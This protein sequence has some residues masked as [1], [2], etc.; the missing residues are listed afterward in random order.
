[1]TEQN[2]IK[3]NSFFSQEQVK[4]SKDVSFYY[5][6]EMAIKSLGISKS[7]FYKRTGISRQL[8]YRYSW[9][10]WTIPDHV[11]IKLCDLFGKPFRDLFLIAQE[12]EK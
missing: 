6:S 11:K 9:G 12:K 8:W 5:R 1:M 4:E 10:F 3:D 7:E 2:K